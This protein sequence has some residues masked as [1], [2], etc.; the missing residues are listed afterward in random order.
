[1]PPKNKFSK[2]QII[3]KG[4]EIAKNEGIEAISVRRIAKELNSSIAPI[5]VNFKD[6]NELK[7]AVVNKVFEISK[8]FS[9][10]KFTGDKFLDIGIASLKFANEYSVLFRELVLTKNEYMKDYDE[11]VGEDILDFIS[12]D[13]ELKN[14]TKDELNTIFLKMRV[15]QLGLSAMVANEF[16]PEYFDED[17][18]INL[19]KS[20][21]EDVINNSIFRKKEENGGK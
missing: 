9:N 14:F 1:M 11:K 2:Q 8:D 16:L 17:K 12:E 4:F 15:F 3:E 18:Q 5:Y 7:R 13:N 19:L 20:A 21:G 6:I 10:I